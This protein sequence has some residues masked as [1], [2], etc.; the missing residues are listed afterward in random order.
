M[1][2]I[3]VKPIISVLEFPMLD[4]IRMSIT[5][6]DYVETSNKDNDFKWGWNK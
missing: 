1:K 2:Q 3:Y 4:V 5:G 6:G